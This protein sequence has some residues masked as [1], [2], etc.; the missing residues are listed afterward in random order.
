MYRSD[1][2]IKNFRGTIQIREVHQRIEHIR[3]LHPSLLRT[4]FAFAAANDRATISVG[5]ASF[6]CYTSHRA[7]G[8]HVLWLNHR[9]GTQKV[10]EEEDPRS[11][12]GTHELATS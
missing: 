3:E 12:E 11:Q 6:K 5:I 9:S 8:I 2:R 1:T 4:I 10:Q 7:P